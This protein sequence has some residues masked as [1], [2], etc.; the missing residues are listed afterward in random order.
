MTNTLT[1]VPGIRVGHATDLD[2]ATGCTVVICPPGTTGGVDVRGGGPGTRETDLLDPARH[3]EHVHAVML[4]GGSAFGLAAADGAMRYLEEHRIGYD[5]FPGVVIPIVPAAI[6]FDLMIARSDVRPTADMGYAACVAATNA[7]APQGNV[8]AG[9]GCTVGKLL[10]MEF[11]TKS[12]IGS[13]S[14]DLGDGLLVAALVAVNAG[15]DVIDERGDILAGV[16]QPPDGNRFLGTL[17]LLKDYARKVE[18]PAPTSNTVI[19]VVATNARLSKAHVTRVAQ[20]AHDGLARAVKPAHMMREG[21][22]IFALATGE[23]EADVSVIGAFAAEVTA[24]AI[25]SGVRAA[26]SLAGIR[27]WND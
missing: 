8:G 19:G 14:M 1:D 12:G 20:M 7:P 3:V 26:T 13:A 17:N 18:G 5:K 24:Q 2:A 15:G 6:L 11:A 23:I 22:T 21:D 16:R 27:A 4:S 10:G 25:R 9:A